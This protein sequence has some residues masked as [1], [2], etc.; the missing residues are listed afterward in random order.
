MGLE[1]PFKD[2]LLDS[3][4]CEDSISESGQSDFI[5]DDV[6]GGLLRLLSMLEDDLLHKGE[7]LQCFLFSHAWSL[8]S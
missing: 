7:S 3:S 4:L 8:S 6:W 1:A 2:I 5:C